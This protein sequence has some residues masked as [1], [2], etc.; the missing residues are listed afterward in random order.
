MTTEDGTVRCPPMHTP[1]QTSRETACT[2]WN[3]PI[4]TL[5]HRRR[6]GVIGFAIIRL[7]SSSALLHEYRTVGGSPSLLRP[8]D[9]TGRKH[10]DDDLW[11]GNDPLCRNL[12]D[13]VAQSHSTQVIAS[14][15][16][17]VSLTFRL[18]R[19]ADGQ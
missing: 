11:L 6:N 17:G 5:G 8:A 12:P 9:R 7:L 4:P 19:S 13:G 15:A 16:R 2:L 18:R 14:G 1:M 10:V 3:F